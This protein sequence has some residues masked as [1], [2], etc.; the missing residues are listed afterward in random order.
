MLCCV[1]FPVTT[2][3]VP[4]SGGNVV[5]F[6]VHV[7]LGASAAINRY[8]L[9]LF[10][11]HWNL[12]PKSTWGLNHTY[13]KTW[14]LVCMQWAVIFSGQKST[15]VMPK[16]EWALNVL[17]W[18]FCWNMT[19]GNFH[20]KLFKKEFLFLT[21]SLQNVEWHFINILPYLII[22]MTDAES[23]LRLLHIKDTV[24]TRV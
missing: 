2:L 1:S 18:A 12:L 16:C 5:W 23:H 14:D 20:L 13:W 17:N 22:T 9:W 8:T 7:C 4:S 21:V 3:H 24:Y 11:L 10:P 19:I 6:S 15:S